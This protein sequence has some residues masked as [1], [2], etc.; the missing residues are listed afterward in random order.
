MRC[1]SGD[2]EPCSNV[3]RRFIGVLA[4]LTARVTMN[5]CAVPSARCHAASQSQTRSPTRPSATPSPT[6]SIVPAPS[7]LGTSSETEARHPRV[8]RGAPSSRG[9]HAR[10]VQLDLHSPGPG[11]G[12]GSLDEAKDFA[13]TREGN[14]NRLTATSFAEPLTVTSGASLETHSGKGG[15]A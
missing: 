7:W 13:P 11:S 12:Q 9:I 8:P 2:A 14:T 15:S 3:H 5:S 4:P 6:A 1:Q 10:D